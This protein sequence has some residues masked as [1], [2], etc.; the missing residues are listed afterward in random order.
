MGPLLFIIFI[1]DID[2]E[3]LCEISKF[4]DERKIAS[5]VNTL[6]DIRLMQQTLNKLVSW[7]N[8]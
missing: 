4:A 7:A 1:G 5:Q 8:R 2:E 6:K 3:V